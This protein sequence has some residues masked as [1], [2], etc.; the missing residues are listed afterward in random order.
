MN[1]TPLT[2]RDDD[3]DEKNDHKSATDPEHQVPTLNGDD[4]SAIEQDDG[5]TRIEAL[6]E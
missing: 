3:N 2:A 6:C 1:E 5:V 4:E